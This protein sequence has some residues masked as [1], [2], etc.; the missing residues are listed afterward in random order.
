MLQGY[1]PPVAVICCFMTNHMKHSGIRKLY[2][3]KLM[4]PIEQEAAQDLVTCFCS[5]VSGA[6]GQKT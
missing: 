4:D 3:I 5:T 2:F 6:L 1:H